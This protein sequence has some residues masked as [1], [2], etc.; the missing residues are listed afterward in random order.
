MAEFILKHPSGRDRWMKMDRGGVK[1]VALSTAADAFADPDSAMAAFKSGRL[2]MIAK[3]QL[4]AKAEIARGIKITSLYYPRD[5]RNPEAADFLPEWVHEKG[6]KPS[7]ES[8]ATE[9]D[10]LGLIEL[11]FVKNEHGWLGRAN[12]GGFAEKLNFH[13]A[14]PFLSLESA[15]SARK[16]PRFGAGPAS[17]IKGSMAFSQVRPERAD[18]VDAQ[19]LGIAAACEARE[20]G[21][22]IE[23]AAMAR[24]QDL[25]AASAKR[26]KPKARL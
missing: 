11:W 22:E 24:I 26:P 16:H 7:L 15:Q 12:D 5:S 20:I 19:T 2:A 6:F 21:S 10:L 1:W 14:Q 8:R 18:C 25:S 4:K 17:Y 23:A 13:E 3:A 9:S